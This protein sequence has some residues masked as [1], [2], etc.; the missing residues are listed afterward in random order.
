[1]GLRE[2]A[3]SAIQ[4]RKIGNLMKEIELKAQYDSLKRLELE[5]YLKEQGFQEVLQRCQWFP[6]RSEPPRAGNPGGRR[7]QNATDSAGLGF[8]LRCGGEEAPERIQE[9]G[10]YRLSGRTGRTGK[11]H[12][13]RGCSS[14]NGIKICHRKSPPGIS[15][16][17]VIHPSGHRASNIPRTGDGVPRGLRRRKCLSERLEIIYK[18]MLFNGNC[19]PLFF[20]Q[21]GQ[22]PRLFFFA[23]TCSL[24]FINIPQSQFFQRIGNFPQE[25]EKLYTISW[26]TDCW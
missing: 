4:E 25:F 19:F 13:T 1:M 24:Q 23:L 6:H 14:G 22:K 26:T 21:P 11:L 8:S 7:T 3:F 18:K 15:F 9:R 5:Q 20:S 16:W 2:T 10:P 17:A 12:W